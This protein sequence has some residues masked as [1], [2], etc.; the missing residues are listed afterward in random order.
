MPEAESLPTASRE[1]EEAL[2]IRIHGSSDRPALIYLPGTHGDWSVIAGLRNLL[3]PQFCFVEFT[4][5]RTTTWTLA[6]YAN[7]VQKT[8]KANGLLQGWL[9]GE[10]FGSQIAWLLAGDPQ[11]DFKCQGIIL[12]GGFGR[13]PLSWGVQ[14]ASAGFQRFMS[15][16]RRV[17]QALRN[18]AGYVRRF[19]EQTPETA[20]SVATFIERRTLEDARAA[21]HRL[22]LIR[23]HAPAE[24][25]QRTEVPVFSL[26][27]FWDQLV[28]WILVTP[29]LH[30]NCPG[31]RDSKLILKADHNVLFS[32]PTKSARAIQKWIGR[33]N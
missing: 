18:Y 4:Y 9:L 8:L 28:P 13:H 33:V 25:V 16:E 14:L 15:N 17:Q 21:V 24:L 6:D 23:A 31:Y 5:P 32:A 20:G 30:R 19:Y 29:W 3:L 7:N 1:A 27:G 22:H 26:S 2:Q 11:T 12:A 10:S